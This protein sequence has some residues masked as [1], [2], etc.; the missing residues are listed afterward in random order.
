VGDQ[1]EE[2]DGLMQPV[3]EAASVA[4]AALAEAALITERGY[5]LS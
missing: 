3:A 2:E 4:D 1:E 5:G